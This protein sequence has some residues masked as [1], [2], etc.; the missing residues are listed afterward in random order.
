[1]IF[2]QK[3]RHENVKVI[4]NSGATPRKKYSNL[5]ERQPDDLIRQ[6]LGEK[7]L[8]EDARV[9]EDH[10]TEEPMGATERNVDDAQSTNPRDFIEDYLADGSDEE[11]TSE[12]ESRSWKHSRRA[13]VAFAVA[14]AALGGIWYIASHF[15]RAMPLERVSVRGANLLSESEVISLAAVDKNDRFYQIDL[16]TLQRRLLRHS[17]IKSA[18]PRRELNPST[19]VLDI[20]ERQPVAMLRSDATGEAFIIDRDGVLLRPKLIAGLRDPAR[21]MQVPLLTGVTERDTV[22]YQAMARLVAMIGAMDSGA[23]RTEIGEL[24]R[25]PTGAYVIYTAE[26]QTPIF[27]G[28]PF[29]ARFQT[30]VEEQQSR[31]ST[32]KE[33]G[34]LFNEQLRLLAKMW[35]TKLKNDLRA[36]NALYVDARFQGQII[37]KHRRQRSGSTPLALNSRS[38]RAPLLT[39][40]IKNSVGQDR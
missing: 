34:P 40:V 25:T 13:P 38:N 21:L 6:R 26:T 1:L 36:G 23:L 8:L 35:R 3:Y 9:V 39:S 29:D 11:D 37:L 28:S 5:P 2:I 22:G 17:L 16:K 32:A 10:S 12:I 14:L 31:A 27:I 30:A 7:K 18:H 4:I 20:E 19:I 15:D 33:T 24:C